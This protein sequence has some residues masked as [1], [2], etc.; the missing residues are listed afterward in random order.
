MTMTK[1]GNGEFEFVKDNSTREMYQ[2]AH[3][4]ITEVRLWDWLANYDVDEEK[5]FMFSVGVELEMIGEKMREQDVAQLHSGYSYGVTMRSMH[6][7]AK[8]GYGMFRDNYLGGK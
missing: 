4:A 1:Y 8:N 3:W 7:I 5:G 6:Y 2:N